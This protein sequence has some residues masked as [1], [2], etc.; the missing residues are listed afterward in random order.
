MFI[1][2]WKHYI[3]IQSIVLFINIVLLFYLCLEYDLCD[4]FTLTKL[5]PFTA[6]VLLCDN[7]KMGINT[8]KITRHFLLIVRFYLFF[9]F[10]FS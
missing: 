6:L 10:L 2:V 1:I 3:F 8:T 7:I 4:K 9:T 5:Y